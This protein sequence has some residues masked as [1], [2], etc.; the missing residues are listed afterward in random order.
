MTLVAGSL[1]SQLS[2]IEATGCLEVASAPTRPFAAGDYI[3]LTR[4]ACAGA[5]PAYRVR[6]YGDGRVY[7]SGQ[8]YVQVVGLATGNVG[9]AAVRS[10]LEKLRVG[11]YWGLCDSYNRRVTGVPAVVTAIH[12]AGVEKSVFDHAD[13][14]PQWLHELDG[15]IDSLAGTARWI[16]T[17]LTS[18]VGSPPSIQPGPP[19]PIQPGLS[20]PVEV[21]GN[22]P[23]GYSLGVY[24]RH[25]DNDHLIRPGTSF[26]LADPGLGEL[27]FDDLMA[28]VIVKGPIVKGDL[29]I[30]W[31]I[32]GSIVDA[33]AV[34][35]NTMI[36]GRFEP[37]PARYDV[38]LRQGGHDCCGV[39]IRHHKLKTPAQGGP[40]VSISSASSASQRSLCRQNPKT[41]VGSRVRSARKNAASAT[42][43]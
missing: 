1:S 39:F 23:A 6:V 40:T 19:P 35:P 2:P 26:A 3:Q 28:A 33:R 10:L 29:F 43:G 25:A 16:G 22:A 21:V 9:P 38:V 17:P 27:G 30:Q 24:S 31:Q 8:S 5:C 32:N 12:Y 34:L 11:G 42:A 41:R 37:Y 13:A 18:G 7:W 20:V 14:A 4:S 36:S 15:D